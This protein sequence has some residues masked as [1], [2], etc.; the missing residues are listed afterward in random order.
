MTV[1]YEDNNLY[2]INKPAGLSTESGHSKHPS[3]E[4]EAMAFLT[5]ELGHKPRYLRAV[6]RLDRASSGVLV[7]AKNKTALSH[8]MSQFE[9]RETDKTYRAVVQTAPPAS[10]GTIT[11]Y[12]KRTEDRRQAIVLP[13]PAENAQAAT[14]DYQVLGEHPQG[15]ELR[16][17]PH[18]GRFHQIR[19]QMAFIGSPIVGDVLYGGQPWMEHAIMLHA[20]KM[21]LAHPNSGQELTFECLPDWATYRT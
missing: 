12:L 7:L 5:A 15:F 8:L 14:L 17:H 4:D 9:H 20:E 1:L 19:A 18:S 13:R 21:V 3:A 10:T 2:V 6:H 16:L 11:H